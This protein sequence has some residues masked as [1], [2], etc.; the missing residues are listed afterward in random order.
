MIERRYDIDWLRVGAT[1]LLFVFHVGKVFD[2]APFYHV[3]N[4]EV[5]FGMLIVCAFGPSDKR[6]SIL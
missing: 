1:Y 4:A 5:S 3:R 6:M 2:P